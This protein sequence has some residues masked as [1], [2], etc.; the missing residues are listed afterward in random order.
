MRALRLQP[1]DNVYELPL[2]DWNGEKGQYRDVDEGRAQEV[3][4][5]TNKKPVIRMGHF[6]IWFKTT[7]LSLF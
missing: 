5:C 3:K 6:L 1:D 2:D 7:S 4:L